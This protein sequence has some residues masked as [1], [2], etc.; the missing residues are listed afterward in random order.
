MTFL[1]VTNIIWAAHT[2]QLTQMVFRTIGT[3]SGSDIFIW[4]MRS[5]NPESDGNRLFPQ[6]IG[7]ILMSLLSAILPNVLASA[8]ECSG[9][10]KLLR[11]QKAERVAHN[12]S[13]AIGVFGMCQLTI[14]NCKCGQSKVC[15]GFAAAGG[16]PYQIDDAP[17]RGLI[18][19]YGVDIHQQKRYL[20]RSPSAFIVTLPAVIHATKSIG[21]FFVPGVT[22][23]VC[24]GHTSL[25]CNM[26]SLHKHCTI[27]Q[28]KGGVCFV[29]LFQRINS[30]VHSL[31]CPPAFSDIIGGSGFV[32]GIECCGYSFQI[33]HPISIQVDQTPHG[34][35]FGGSVG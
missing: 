30:S 34:C 8:N 17:L 11:R 33:V 27:R 25:H 19:N 6:R 10:G 31:I 29:I 23:G 12:N 15:L 22:V 24:F 3:L 13:R 5:A 2:L 9:A 14:E 26:N 1:F 4:N 21:Y 20:E 35:K 18:I 32:S 7:G 28:Q 16:K